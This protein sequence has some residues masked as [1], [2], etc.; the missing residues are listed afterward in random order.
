MNL[1]LITLSN[2]RAFFSNLNSKLTGFTTSGKNYKLNQD[3]NGNYYTN[4]PWENTTYNIAN[5]STPGLVK[6]STTGTTANRDYNVEVKN[7]GTMK[8]NV[9]WENTTYDL[10]PYKIKSDFSF[11]NN[12]KTLYITV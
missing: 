8:V 7:D 9:P 5:T 11:D 2:L 12:S 6:S 10:S 1:K 3:S 4:V